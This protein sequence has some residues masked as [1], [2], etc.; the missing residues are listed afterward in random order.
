MKKKSKLNLDYNEIKN[1]NLKKKNNYVWIFLKRCQVLKV[2]YERGWKD[3]Q[4]VLKIDPI[5]NLKN[6]KFKIDSFKNKNFDNKFHE[7][8]CNKRYD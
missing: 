2:L 6:L 8:R 5:V 3:Y 7:Q 4:K 1:Y